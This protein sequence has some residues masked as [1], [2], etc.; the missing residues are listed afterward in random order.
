MQE[1]S[2][3]PL[4]FVPPWLLMPMGR[5]YGPVGSEETAF[6]RLE[7]EFPQAMKYFDV[8]KDPSKF[9]QLPYKDLASFINFVQSVASYVSLQYQDRLSSID[10]TMNNAYLR[11]SNN[12]LTNRKIKMVQYYPYKLF[13]IKNLRYVLRNLSVYIGVMDQL[14]DLIKNIKV[15]N[16]NED[17]SVQHHL[18]FVK[19]L[20]LTYIRESVLYLK[21][22]F[23]RY[24]ED[25]KSGYYLKNEF[26]NPSSPEYRETL[27][28]LREQYARPDTR[29]RLQLS[30]SE[31]RE[32][33]QN[34]NKTFKIRQRD[35]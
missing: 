20:F 1:V 23:D 3:S 9:N 33:D 29:S 2:S 10:T 27:S 5:I 30:Q 17:E 31:R 25:L 11:I 26:L 16:P 32:R 34:P 4:G 19:N 35:E 22:T 14:I 13:Y 7:Q 15:D 18:G 6:E 12:V 21:R 28:S 8:V 24:S